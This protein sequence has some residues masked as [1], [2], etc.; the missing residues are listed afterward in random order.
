MSQM[1]INQV[2]AQ[3]RSLSAQTKVGTAAAPQT[4]QTG[5]S[6]FANIMRKGLDAVNQNQMKA[7]ELSDAFARGTP[8]V[9]LPQVMLAGAKA[10]I[11]FH[12]LNEVRN[13]LVSAYQDIMNMQL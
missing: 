11:S 13:R 1:E 5:P 6:E 10:N 7:D 2:L 9:E 4:Q 3:I 8:G 12:A